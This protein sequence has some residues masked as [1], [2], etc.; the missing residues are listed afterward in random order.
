MFFTTQG[1]LRVMNT[2]PEGRDEV[3]P[4]LLFIPS[5]FSFVYQEWV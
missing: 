2:L 3:N 5:S 1:V 4:R